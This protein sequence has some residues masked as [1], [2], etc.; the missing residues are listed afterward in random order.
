MQPASF[1]GFDGCNCFEPSGSTKAMPNHWLQTKQSR[2]STSRPASI[3]FQFWWQ[4]KGFQICQNFPHT[5]LCFNLPT[6]YY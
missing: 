5:S 2:I 3:G 6:Y 1:N 4:Q